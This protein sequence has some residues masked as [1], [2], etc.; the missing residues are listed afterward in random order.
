MR[1]LLP[2]KHQRVISI[3]SQIN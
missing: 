1:A 3:H 2:N